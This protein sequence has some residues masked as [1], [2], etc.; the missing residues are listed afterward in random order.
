ML[1]RSPQFVVKSWWPLVSTWNTN[2]YH[3]WWTQYYDRL[4]EARIEDIKKGAA[5]PLSQS[6]WRKIIRGTGGAKRLIRNT[7]TQSLSFLSTVVG[8]VFPGLP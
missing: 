5:Q 4:F 6:D 7:S 3:S 2:V 1:F 8:G